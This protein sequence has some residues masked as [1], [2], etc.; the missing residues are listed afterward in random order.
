VWTN[1]ARRR[2]RARYVDQRDS[3]GRHGFR[4]ELRQ[5]GIQITYDMTPLRPRSNRYAYVLPVLLL[6]LGSCERRAGGPS[7]ESVA[8]THPASDAGPPGVRR[9]W[10]RSFGP[11]LLVA[12]ESPSEAFVILPD[13]IDA[14]AQAATLPRPAFVTLFGRGGTVQT[15]ELRTGP[16]LGACHTSALAAAP[17]P[18]PW[19][20]G[21]LGGV[22]APIAMDSLESLSGADSAVLVADATRLASS[23]PNDSFGRFAELAFTVRSLWRFTI[24]PAHTVVIATLVRQI[25][26][27]ATPLEERTFLIAERKDGNAPLA[28]KY[29]ERSYGE[30]ETI[31]NWEVL[32]TTA[33][34]DVR[35]V[36]VIV[37]RD[38]GNGIAFS[39][40]QRS[41]DGRWRI[42]WTSPRRNC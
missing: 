10:D 17:P 36:N 8:A 40:I 42:Q 5:S 27:E 18:K 35:K 38:F 9:G 12:A 23:L 14:A 11:V 31:E 4:I 15:A 3:G 37:S 20:V 24:P 22:V 19:S 34:G 16:D 41:P 33:S 30:G 7:A 26:Q 25:N 13:S 32:A 6:A 28:T 21:F 1:A 2:T 29:S 39:L